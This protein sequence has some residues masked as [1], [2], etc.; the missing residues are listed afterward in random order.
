MDRLAVHPLEF[1]DRIEFDQRGVVAHA[2]GGE[3]D[4]PDHALGQGE[5]GLKLLTALDFP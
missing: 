3:L 2:L 5:Q 4:L 1:V